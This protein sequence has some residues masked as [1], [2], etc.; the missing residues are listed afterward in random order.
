MLRRS[1]GATGCCYPSATNQVVVVL[2]TT[3]VSDQWAAY[4]TI[5]DMPDGYQHETVNHSLHFTD[6][7]TGAYTNTTESLWQNFKEGHKSLYG[8]E[9]ALLNSYMDEFIWEKMYGGTCRGRR[10]KFPEGE[11]K[12]ESELVIY[13]IV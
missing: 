10:D 5:K 6:P 4:S 7:E 2:G 9:R 11:N 3:I 8:T 13:V 1:I 12:F